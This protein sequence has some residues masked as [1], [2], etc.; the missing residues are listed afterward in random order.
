MSSMSELQRRW[1][2][3]VLRQFTGS[4]EKYHPNTA[5]LR[6]GSTQPNR[7]KGTDSTRAHERLGLC[8]LEPPSAVSDYI[9]RSPGVGPFVVTTL[10][11]RRRPLS[12]CWGGSLS[13]C[14]RTQLAPSP[15]ARSGREALRPARRSESVSSAG[16]I[17]ANSP[18]VTL[19][20]RQHF[21]RPTHIAVRYLLEFISSVVF[22]RK[23]RP[24]ILVGST[25]LGS[26]AGRSVSYTSADLVNLLLAVSDL[27]GRLEAL[28]RRGSSCS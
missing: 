21:D 10:H 3:G 1:A 12:H 6:C 25:P 5:Y 24:C 11:E 13:A 22:S 28:C 20:I 18:G 9:G 19:T 16:L 2:H 17:C 14:A 4:N 7:D 15:G 27:T 23:I 26:H 8:Q